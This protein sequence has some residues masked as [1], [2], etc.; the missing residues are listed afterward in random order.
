MMNP[1]QLS[2]CVNTD[3]F[4]T[5]I[6]IGTGKGKEYFQDGADANRG[7]GKSSRQT[8][9]V[10]RSE[11][12]ITEARIPSLEISVGSASDTGANTSTGVGVAGPLPSKLQYIVFFRSIRSEYSHTINISTT[13]SQKISIKRNAQVREITATGSK[14]PSCYATTTAKDCRENHRQK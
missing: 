7:Y 14:Q 13:C 4:T 6:Q 8:L 11:T 9:Q 10:Q 5:S 3:N 2:S 1:K 12:E